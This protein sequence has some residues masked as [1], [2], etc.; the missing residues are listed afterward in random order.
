M[1]KRREIPWPRSYKSMAGQWRSPLIGIRGGWAV[2]VDA[3][4]RSRFMRFLLCLAIQPVVCPA[5]RAS[6][7]CVCRTVPSQPEAGMFAGASSPNAGASPGSGRRLLCSI[8]TWSD[9]IRRSR[10]AID[11]PMWPF[12]R[13]RVYLLC[14]DSSILMPGCSI[15]MAPASFARFAPMGACSLMMYPIISSTH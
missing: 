12:L 4:S 5:H 8:T 1:L 3:I 10:V 9:L 13:F 11:L 2:P 15:S 6:S 14:L 7:Q